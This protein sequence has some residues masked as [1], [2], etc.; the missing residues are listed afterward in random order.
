LEARLAAVT[1]IVLV[2]MATTLLIELTVRER[3]KLISAK[4]TAALMLTQLLANELT[5][6]VDFD[7]LDDA[8]TSLNFLRSNPDIVGA[9]VFLI[10][11][12][13]KPIAGW[14]AP[15]APRTVRP[16]ADE[17]DGATM[18]REWLVVTRTIF[19]QHNRP[20]ARVRVVFTL[21]PEN[22]AFR[23]NRRQLLVM[24]LGLTVI[25]ALL[26]GLLARRYVVGPIKRLASA[27]TALAGGD[28][29]ARVES[30]AESEIGDLARAFNVMSEAVTSRAAQLRARNDDMKLVL[31]HVAQGLFT[32]DRSGLISSEYSNAL[33]DWLGAPAAADT[34]WSYFGRFDQQIEVRLRLGW[35]AVVE[36]LLPLEVTLDQ[37]PKLLHADERH[38]RIG[39]LPITVSGA[40]AKVLVVVSDIT[41]EVARERADESQRELLRVFEQFTQDRSGFA[42]FI[43]EADALVHKIIQLRG[44]SADLTRS[45]HT[46]KGNCAQF[47]LGT[48]TDVCHRLEGVLIETG[49]ALSDAQRD[50]LR[51]AWGQTRERLTTLLG[52]TRAE[53]FDVEQKDYEHL[54]AELDAGASARR[55]ARE[56]RRWRLEPTARRLDR[57][58]RQAQALAARLGKGPIRVVVEP[59]G[60]RLEAR[61][62]APFWSAFVHVLRNA[63]DH[64]IETECER[65]DAGKQG[66]GTIVL[67]TQLA[68]DEF[69]VEAQDDGRGIDW[70]GLAARCR[71]LGRPCANRQEIEAVLLGIGVSTRA[72]VS[73]HSG[74]G[75]GMGAAAAACSA[76]GGKVSIQSV[77]GC[78]TLVQFRFPMT[79]MGG[80]WDV[81]ASTSAREA[82]QLAGGA[83]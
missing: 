19:G 53:R 58:A 20:L 29:R 5:A 1:S 8:T 28:G 67:R 4:T 76:L 61:V 52:D 59:N 73:E 79:A 16:M 15:V 46:L 30:D 49:L 37:M 82:A 83:S 26:F 80:D 57:L 47:G 14:A 81:A 45:L 43:A 60:L 68:G 7:D 51:L 2:L 63:V 48:V 74:R 62:W 22:E 31:D 54:L 6:A 77:R 36:D 72:E 9:A 24:T 75:V 34:L 11:G 70:E 39:Y 18:S 38:F 3:E 56:L 42:E 64:G 40:L 27:A 50:G 69:V 13:D 71:A 21:D 66:P 17:P 65:S 44:V 32:I 12:S 55:A 41:N 25:A 10:H 33:A 23:A 78:G 35:E